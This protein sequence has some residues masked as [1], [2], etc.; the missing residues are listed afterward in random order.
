MEVIGY[1]TDDWS[2]NSN[3]VIEPQYSSLYVKQL[4][5]MNT[6]NTI[7]N[8]KDKVLGWFSKSS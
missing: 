8:S 2:L 7:R 6:I 4:V 1:D 5:R 3:P